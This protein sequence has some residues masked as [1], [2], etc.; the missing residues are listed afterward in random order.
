MKI[1]N[2][3]FGCGAG[4]PRVF[5]EAARLSAPSGPSSSPFQGARPLW[6]RPLPTRHPPDPACPAGHLPVPQAIGRG[7]SHP[8]PSPQAPPALS[9]WMIRSG[10]RLRREGLGGRCPCGAAH[11]PPLGCPHTRTLVFF[12]LFVAVASYGDIY[13]GTIS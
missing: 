2:L 3:S 12:F 9:F 13:I 1:G 10:F 4:R 7:A 6:S 8:S 5:A 11:G